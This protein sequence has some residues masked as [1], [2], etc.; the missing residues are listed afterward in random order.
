MELKLLRKQVAV[1]FEEYNKQQD[2]I[3]VLCRN[4]N[5]MREKL[6]AVCQLVGD[7]QNLPEDSL[8]AR[9]HRLEERMR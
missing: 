8:R 5:V 7:L 2:T 4:M 1:L 6:D 9:V 3:D